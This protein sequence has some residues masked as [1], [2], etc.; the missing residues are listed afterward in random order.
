MGGFVEDESQ[1]AGTREAVDKEATAST[2]AVLVSVSGESVLKGSVYCCCCLRNSCNEGEGREG[3][4]EG[5]RD[6]GREGWKEGVRER[7]KG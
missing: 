5:G 6:G 7:V 2:S 1:A 4:M 3:G